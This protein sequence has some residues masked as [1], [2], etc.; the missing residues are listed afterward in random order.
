MS[1]EIPYFK[2][3]ICS[4]CFNFV[5]KHFLNIFQHT[6]TKISGYWFPKHWTEGEVTLSPVNFQILRFKN[7]SWNVSFWFKKVISTHLRASMKNGKW[8]RAQI[9]WQMNFNMTD[10]FR[11]FKLKRVYW[12]MQ[13]KKGYSETF[14]KGLFL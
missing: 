9:Y 1:K 5:F 12:Q 4:K 8:I 14:Q 3:I 7:I 13:E 11:T 2:A 10:F 6:K